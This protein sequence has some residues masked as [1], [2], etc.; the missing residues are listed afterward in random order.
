MQGL[1]PGRLL[2]RHRYPSAVLTCEAA[3]HQRGKSRRAVVASATLTAALRG[4][5]R[6]PQVTRVTQPEAG[7]QSA[8]LMAALRPLVEEDAARPFWS[9][10]SARSSCPA[11]FL[12]RIPRMAGT[13]RSPSSAMY[14][15]TSPALMNA[16]TSPASG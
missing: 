6:C 4:G 14:S 11:G 2:G 10:Q 3:R 8:G 7:M 5:Q 15:I 9:S 16:L 13:G 12:A 1:E